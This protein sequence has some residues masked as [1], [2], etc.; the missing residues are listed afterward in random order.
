[1]LMLAC[2]VLVAFHAGCSR[3]SVG[4]DESTAGHMFVRASHSLMRK[5]GR[6][7]INARDATLRYVLGAAAN[8]SAR[9]VRV[10]TVCHAHATSSCS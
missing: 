4:A 6:Q 5:R 1:V 9:C 7:D 2:R 3:P 8:R 10:G